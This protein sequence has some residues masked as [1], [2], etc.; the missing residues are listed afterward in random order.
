MSSKITNNGFSD[1]L[2]LIRKELSCTQ[3]EF[4]DKLN[5]PVTTYQH[6]ERGET[7]A[8][9]SLATKISEYGYSL[10]WLLMGKGTPTA[11]EDEYLP[12]QNL[13]KANNEVEQQ[14]MAL[15]KG[16]VD[17]QRA[18]DIDRGLIELEKY[19]PE[20]FRRVESYIK[21]TVDAVRARAEKSPYQGIERRT[22]QRRVIND[23][24]QAPD[25]VDR[26]SGESRRKAG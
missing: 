25:G 23:P 4:A 26:R 7:E 13:P 22:E 15:V 8:P 19:D 18:L 16:F 9:I 20:T 1:R 24:T 10:V 11:K 6:Y 17:K 3:R 12:N 21:G 2:K 14:H 5:I